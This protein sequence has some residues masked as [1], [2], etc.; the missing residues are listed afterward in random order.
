MSQ[1][2]RLLVRSQDRP[3][4]NIIDIAPTIQNE[5]YGLANKAD[6]KRG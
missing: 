2:L 6:Q 5:G 4:E 1:S 3:K